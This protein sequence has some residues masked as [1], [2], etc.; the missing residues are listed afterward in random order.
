MSSMGNFTEEE[1]M[2]IGK[3]VER[4]EMRKKEILE[5]AERQKRRIDEEY[6]KQIKA[7]YEQ[8]ERLIREEMKK[9]EN[10]DQSTSEAEASSLLKEI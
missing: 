7:L 1:R 9:R 6:L 2:L 3:Q 4:Y 10:A 8:Q 5:D